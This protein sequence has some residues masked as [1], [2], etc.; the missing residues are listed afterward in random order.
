MIEI[1]SAIEQAKLMIERKLS[2]S[3]KESNDRIITKI[4]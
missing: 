4:E 1:V 3:V 2:C